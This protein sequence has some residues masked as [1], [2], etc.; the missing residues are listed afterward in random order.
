VLVVG[1]TGGVASGKTETAN[2]FRA[3]G[4]VVLEADELGHRLLREGPIKAA[5]V[6]AFGSGILGSS[7]EID[8][9]VL[10]RLAFRNRASLSQLNA[11]CHPPL[12]ERL[13]TAV[14][15]AR[16]RSGGVF[17][18]VAA[19]LVDWGLYGD[20]DR[21]VTVEASPENRARRLMH[22]HGYTRS[23]AE[24]RVRCQIDRA[25]RVGVADYVIDGDAPL[26]DMLIAA[27]G[28]WELLQ[29][30]ACP[31]SGGGTDHGMA[32]ASR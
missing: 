32:R 6:S 11:I 20:M 2:L 30:E 4:G 27:Q 28:V 12:L 21:V 7:G 8:R 22:E 14:R 16:E 13:R 31:S 9:R 25:S 19:L 10:G 1:L 17:V 24:R 3:Q 18:L 29:E 26:P 23:E 15:A 5:L